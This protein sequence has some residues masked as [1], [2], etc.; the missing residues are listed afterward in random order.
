MPGS[1]LGLS[2]AR[3]VVL[4]HGGTMQVRPGPDGRGLVVV[5]ALPAE[6]AG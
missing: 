5:L 6:F 4:R 1:G 2:I 3:S